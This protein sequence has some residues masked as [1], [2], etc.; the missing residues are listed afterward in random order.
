MAKKP[1]PAELKKQGEELSKQIADIR[2]K[3]LNFAMIMGKDALAFVTDRKKNTDILWRQ[4]KGEVG[5]SKGAKGVVSMRGKMLVLDADDPSSVPGPMLKAAKKYFSERG[6][7]LRI[8]LKGE[9]EAEADED[10]ADAKAAPEKAKKP[11]A[12]ADEQAAKPAKAAAD[13][14]SGDDKKADAKAEDG[15]GQDDRTDALRESLM[16]DF[17]AMKPDLDVSAKA[18][19][20]VHKKINGLA[21]VFT[22]TIQTDVKKAH[23]VMGLLQT[24]LKTAKDKGQLDAKGEGG[25]NLAA[26]SARRKKLAALERGVDKLLERLG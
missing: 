24:T 20:G 18:D 5:G 17:N 2:K 6:V 19:G 11:D 7:A 8:V 13:A 3:D 26:S 16:Q 4:A 14:P 15:G 25:P 12:K 1:S 22:D 21:R 9:E 23:S 10:E